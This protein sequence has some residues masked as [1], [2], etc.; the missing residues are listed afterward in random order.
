ML[1]TFSVEDFVEYQVKIFLLTKRFYRVHEARSRNS[2]N[3]GLG[4]SIIKHI[5]RHNAELTINSIEEKE[6]NFLLFLIDPLCC[7]KT[8]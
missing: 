7:R 5:N 2:G 1:I 3:T 6:L 4:L 8:T